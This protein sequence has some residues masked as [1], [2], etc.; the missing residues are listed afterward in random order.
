MR[1]CRCARFIRRSP[2]TRVAKRL[3]FL[4]KQMHA[5]DQ[6]HEQMTPTRRGRAS[7]RGRGSGAASLPRRGR[8]PLGGAAECGPGCRPAWPLQRPASGDGGRI[9]ALISLSQCDPPTRRGRRTPQ[10]RTPPTHAQVFLNYSNVALG[11]EIVP[12]RFMFY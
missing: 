5:N 1:D 8:E 10:D 9:S 2:L 7:A 4:E 3:H 6:Q 11:L 12:F